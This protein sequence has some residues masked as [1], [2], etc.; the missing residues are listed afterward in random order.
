MCDFYTQ[1]SEVSQLTGCN[2]TKGRLLQRLLPWSFLGKF[3]IERHAVILER[4][5]KE[6]EEIYV[7]LGFIYV[8]GMKN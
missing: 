1:S 4:K 8:S 2:I 6:I 5:Q 7:I 3:R